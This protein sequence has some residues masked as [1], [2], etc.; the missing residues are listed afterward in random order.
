LGKE[1]SFLSTNNP[2]VGVM[3]FK[4]MED[5]D[6][7]V[8]R[9]NELSGKDL[10]GIKM[11][12]PAKITDAYE[13]N[14]QEQ[15]IGNVD[16]SGNDLAFDL[17]HFTI[18]SFAVKLASPAVASPAIEQTAVA[19]SYNRDVMSFDNNRDDGDFARGWNLPAELVPDVITSEGI[20]FKMGSKEDEQN[21]AVTCKGQEITLP[22]GNFSTLYI[23]AAADRDT[24]GDFV[25]GNQTYP[26]KIQQWEGFVG[27]WYAR[28]FAK[29]E[30]TV[31]SINSPFAKKA[32]IAWFAS[33]VHQQYPSENVAYRY[34]YLY[35]YSIPVPAGATKL[36]LP[37]NER[38]KILAITAAKGN[39]NV[40]PLQP[41]YDDFENSKAVTL[42]N[43]GK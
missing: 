19:L 4:K 14:G 43:Q 28:Q 33:H 31:T 6:Y 20:N 25:I 35:K 26:L 37:N 40:T 15:K 18:K 34:C 13:I 24:Q 5:G 9:V 16:F 2:Q 8:I 10:T 36:V 17:S 1:F 38:I 32:N 7:Y 22:A 23:L 39:D 42:I 11:T 41:L 30:I 21:N 29:D 27:Q 12:L 3:A